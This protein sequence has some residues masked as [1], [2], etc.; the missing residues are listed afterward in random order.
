[1]ENAFLQFGAVPAEMLIDNAKALV[2]HHDAV[3]RDVR[4]NARLH[5]FAP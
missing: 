2:E 1:M 5:A 3:T 4:F